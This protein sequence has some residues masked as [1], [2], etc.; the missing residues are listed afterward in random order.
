[1]D[2][3]EQQLVVLRSGGPWLQEGEEIVDPQIAALCDCAFR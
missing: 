2:D 3:D 1:M